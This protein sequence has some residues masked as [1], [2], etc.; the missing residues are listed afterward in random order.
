MSYYSH[1]LKQRFPI[2]SLLLAVSCLIAT[3]PQFILPAAYSKLAGHFPSVN[4]LYLATLPAFTHAA[5]PD[6]RLVHLLGNTLIILCF[7]SLA[8][9][10]LGRNRFA[11]ISL[12]TFFTS[13]FVVYLHY[14][15][16]T[17]EYH[18]AS[19]ICFG[20]LSLFLLLLIILIEQQ[21]WDILQHP[22]AVF[23]IAFSAFCVF[24]IPVVEVVVQKAGFFENFGQTIHLLSYV[25][26][27][28]PIL[29]W[30][31]EI[32]ETILRIIT[33]GVPRENVRKKWIPQVLL[34][35]VLALNLSNTV[36]VVHE[37]TTNPFTYLA[38]PAAST[39]IASMG[40]E[41]LVSFSHPVEERSERLIRRSITYQDDRE[42]PEV[43]VEWVDGKHMRLRFSRPFSKGENLLLIYSVRRST[44]QGSRI[45]EE[46][47]IQY[48]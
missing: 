19:G 40:T 41:V 20:Y 36:V 24:G 12:L 5:A 14:Y 18:G 26:V 21:R 33:E 7:G 10:V 27:F 1:L 9:I 23:L 47:T 22:I 31:K 34:L 39:P 35:L 44:Y 15:G 29:I 30:R 37:V 32:E 11:L 28:V 42:S 17:E 4:Y 45:E 25:L 13:T 3:L 38:E 43:N 8:E 46:T 48:K 6:F 2:L 16:T